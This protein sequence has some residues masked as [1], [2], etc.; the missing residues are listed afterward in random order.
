MNITKQKQ[1]KKT[2]K[3]LA[4]GTGKEEGQTGSREL[5]GTNYQVKNKQ[6]TRI[7]C[8]TQGISA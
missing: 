3:W 2:N 7:Y 8:T 1:I 4:M 5:R 6:A